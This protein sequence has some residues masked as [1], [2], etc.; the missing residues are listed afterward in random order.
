MIFSFN[1]YLPTLF[2]PYNETGI[3]TPKCCQSGKEDI[4]KSSFS[5]DGIYTSCMYLLSKVP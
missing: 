1:T 5:E 4:H 2:S 3:D